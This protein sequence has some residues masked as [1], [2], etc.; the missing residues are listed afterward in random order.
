MK[1][2]DLGASVEVIVSANGCKDNTKEYMEGLCKSYNG[3][4]FKLIWSDEPTGFIKAT[5]DG[6]EAASG[7]FII[8]L[9]ND[10]ELL[11]QPRNSWIHQLVEPFFRDEKMAV[12]GPFLIGY[13]RY[14]MFFCAMIKKSMF[15][16][17]GLLDE[18]F[19]PGMG[20]DVDFC[21]KVKK[22]GYKIEQVPYYSDNLPNRGF[23][24]GGFPICHAGNKTFIDAFAKGTEDILDRNKKILADR[25][26]D[27]YPKVVK[28]NLGCGD[29]LE[30]GYINIDAYNP[31]AD[32]KA[33]AVK[34]PLP[35]DWADEIMSMHMFEH[36]SPYDV[37]DALAEWK[38]VL[39]PG[40]RLILEMPDIMAMCKEFV[41]PATSKGKRY[42]LLNCFY[43]TTQIAHPHLWGWYPEILA[44]HLWNAGYRNIIECALQYTDHWGRN[45]RMECQK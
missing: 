32:M 19:A 18:I 22:G 20:E 38:R 39:K 9:N 37:M 4:A 27:L 7:E 31:A 2:T 36:L 10:T 17:F 15:D 1:Y 24:L 16:Q 8:L 11:N 25:Y 28:L 33:N 35:N 14:V 45:F 13:P 42:E 44:D 30:K 5:N 12:T 23:M 29:R 6:I 3:K 26:P 41:D 40:G 34:L 43:G 21:I